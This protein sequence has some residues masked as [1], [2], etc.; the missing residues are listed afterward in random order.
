MKTAHVYS[1]TPIRP[2]VWQIAEEDGVCCTLIKGSDLAVLIDT[3]YG[4][5]DLRSFVEQSVTTPYMVIN[6]HGHPDHT[7]GN[8]WFDTVWAVQEEW[9]LIEYFEEAPRTYERKALQFGQQLS[10]GDLHIDIVPLIGHTKASAGF[11]IRE[12]RLLVAG[13]ALNEGLWLFNYGSL[14]MKQ[15]YTTL[16]NAMQLNFDSYIWGHCH[17][18]YRKEQLLPHIRNI[19]NLKIDQATRQDIFGFETYTSCYE[20]E[21]GKSAI[22]FTLDRLD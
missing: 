19:E 9:D 6:S 7:G 14:P 1:Y 11:L 2:N 18:E 20:N 21:H 13:D 10:L 16:Q 5:W 15:L 17:E 12:E 4:S 8:H 22:T 3:G